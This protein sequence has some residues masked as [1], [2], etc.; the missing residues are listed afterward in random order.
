MCL[1]DLAAQAQRAIEVWDV[2]KDGQAV[3]RLVGVLQLLCAT[4]ELK[5]QILG[6]SC[7][8]WELLQSRKE[9]E[10]D[11]TYAA[12]VA[13]QAKDVHTCVEKLMLVAFG[14]NL[15]WCCFC[16]LQGI[17][18]DEYTYWPA[19]SSLQPQS[20]NSRLIII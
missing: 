19:P 6:R 14:M 7:Q 12:L 1:S 3:P 9:L 8:D 2:L 16:S 20:V 5:Q 11:A 13:L 17:N 4:S 10:G 15:C 18:K